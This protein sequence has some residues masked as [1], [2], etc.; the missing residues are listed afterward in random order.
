MPKTNRPPQMM[1]REAMVSATSTGLCR[2]RR[3]TPATP[4]MCPASAASREE[5]HELELARA[6]AQVV[7]PRRHHVPAA[8]ARQPGHGELLVELRDHVA[9][10]GILVRQE[11]ADLHR[12]SARAAARRGARPR[13]WRRSWPT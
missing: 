12:L 4:V 7:L 2:P 13:P 3:R 9:A 11:D 10:H 8:I 5:G 1:S 6:L